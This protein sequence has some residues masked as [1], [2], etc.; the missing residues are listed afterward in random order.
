MFEPAVERDTDL[1]ILAGDIFTGTR[2]V[3]W[4]QQTFPDKPVL[5]VLGNHEFYGHKFP[6]MYD[7]LKDKAAGT[8]VHVL[9]NDVFE[10]GDWVVLGCTLW[11]DFRLAGIEEKTGLWC[12]KYHMNDYRRIRDSN[13]NYCKLH[14]AT[15]CDYHKQ[16]LAWLKS[17]L[18]TYRDR[19]T[20]VMTHH[21]P[22][23]KLTTSKLF[24]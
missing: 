22:S 16:S 6:R 9:E 15:I 11:T 2:G 7:K 14:P 19:K 23:S 13:R 10:W 1:I 20:L 5:Y 8:N 3:T 4:A 18:D 12:A 21:A 24:Y 17:N